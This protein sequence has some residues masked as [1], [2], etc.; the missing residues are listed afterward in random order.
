MIWTAD[1]W[2]KR[3]RV[4]VMRQADLVRCI[5]NLIRACTVCGWRK[6]QGKSMRFS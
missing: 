3:R 2:L 5:S 6:S 1:C 4:S